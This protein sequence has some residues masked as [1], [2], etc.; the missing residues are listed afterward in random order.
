MIARILEADRADYRYK[1]G[2]SV[3]KLHTGVRNI[4]VKYFGEENTSIVEDV[5]I[6]TP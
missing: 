1:E 2:H 3:F 5:L 6:N 4:M